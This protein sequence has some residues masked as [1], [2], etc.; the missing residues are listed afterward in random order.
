[1]RGYFL[2]M[3]NVNREKTIQH[4]KLEVESWSRLINF[5]QQENVLLKSRLADFVSGSNS[6][7]EICFAEAFLEDFLS[8]DK[9]ILFFADELKIQSRLLYKEGNNDSMYGWIM[10]NQQR[11][12]VYFIKAEESFF[13]IKQS[14]SNYFTQPLRQ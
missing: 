1:M 8:N 10:E 14:F 6:N 2:N 11:L 9:M 4:C 3:K 12:R 5:F 7:D 13:R